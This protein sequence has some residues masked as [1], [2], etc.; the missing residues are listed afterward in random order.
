LSTLYKIG[1]IDEQAYTKLLEA[2]RCEQVATTEKSERL[3]LSE[4]KAKYETEE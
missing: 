4:L 3:L 1:W 2:R